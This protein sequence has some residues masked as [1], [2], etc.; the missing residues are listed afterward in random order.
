MAARMRAPVPREEVT[1][2]TAPPAAPRPRR[3]PH[4]GTGFPAAPRA[5]RPRDLT[6]RPL[7]RAA[8]VPR[9]R[10]PPAVPELVPSASPQAVRAA[11]AGEGHGRPR[12]SR[13]R[14]RRSPAAGA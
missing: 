6:N 1:P 10:L 11:A 8:F 7:A 14:P 9:A 4:S 13:A 5:P 2:R 12:S 3:A